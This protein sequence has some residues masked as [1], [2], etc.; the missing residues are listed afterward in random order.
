M[1]KKKLFSKYKFYWPLKREPKEKGH[2]GFAIVADFSK[3]NNSQLTWT[4]F[5]FFWS[6]NSFYYFRNVFFFFW[7][8]FSF[9]FAL[10]REIYRER[11][12]CQPSCPY[13]SFANFR[14][15]SFFSPPPLKFMTVFQQLIL[16]QSLF[17][18]F[19]FFFFFNK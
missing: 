3:P 10:D 16:S 13:S 7:I 14:N 2:N 4:G 8:R 11:K 6:L 15:K 18:Y 5:F 17:I 1:E 19:S 9:R 12:R